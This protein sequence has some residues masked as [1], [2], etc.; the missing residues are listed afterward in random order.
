MFSS[1][2]TIQLFVSAQIVG[3]QFL[4]GSLA[5]KFK[6]ALFEN[7]ETSKTLSVR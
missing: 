6:E 4:F 3:L 2:S 1:F 7:L 5:M